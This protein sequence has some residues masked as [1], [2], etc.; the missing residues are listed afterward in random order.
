MRVSKFLVKGGLLALGLVLLCSVAN[1]ESMSMQ[2][3][4]GSLSLT[5]ALQNRDIVVLQVPAGWGESDI[6]AGFIK[7][8]IDGTAISPDITIPKL[9]KVGT[10]VYSPAISFI[11]QYDGTNLKVVT[12]PTT[13]V[14]FGS[15]LDVDIDNLVLGKKIVPVVWST[16][17]YSIL[18]AYSVPA[19]ATAFGLI[20]GASWTLGGTEKTAGAPPAP[21][22]TNST[23]GVVNQVN[24]SMGE[25]YLTLGYDTNYS[26]SGMS[27][28]V[29]GF[30][31][32]PHASTPAAKLIGRIAAAPD[33]LALT[34]G[35]T[36]TLLTT[37]WNAFGPSAT[38]NTY[39]FT[40]KFGGAG[41]GTYVITLESQ[42]PLGAG[43]NF[44]A[45]P[46]PGPWF[47]Y[48]KLGAALN[49]TNYAGSTTNEVRMAYDLVK[50]I[51][52]AAGNK[53]VSTVGA[54]LATSQTP[55]YVLLPLN[56]PDA[57]SAAAALKAS[58]VKE[59]MGAQF[60][61]G[62]VNGDGVT[63]PPA[64]IEFVIKNSQ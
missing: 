53:V 29:V 13:S 15:G 57:S 49:F 45:M 35:T 36:Y 46:S 56:D 11:C 20:V 1:A 50:V 27:L 2:L 48:D 5:T 3:R 25:A 42:A 16:I 55:S 40:T 51:N 34:A 31:A 54:W 44:I 28:E 58:P 33:N 12:G 9:A 62:T 47:A 8:M 30:S 10:T 19:D 37:G 6:I 61:V 18:T 38:P 26:Y 4:Q 59:G 64:K 39:T 32:L 22:V 60:Y 24:V 21:T 52:A 17:R 63:A 43:M 14:N 41:S 23:G 7:P